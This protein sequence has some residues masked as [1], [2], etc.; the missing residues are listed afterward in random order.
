MK[1]GMSTYSLKGA[2]TDG[3]LDLPGIV[4]NAADWGAEHVEV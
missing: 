4:R 3:R 2:F 1:I